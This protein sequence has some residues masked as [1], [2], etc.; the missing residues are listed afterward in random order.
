MAESVTVTETAIVTRRRGRR[1]RPSATTP[2]EEVTTYQVQL[3]V[4]RNAEAI[5]EAQRL[6]GW[7]IYVTHSAIEDVSLVNAMALYGEEWTVC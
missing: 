2:V 3:S 1:G 4:Q 6:A 5:A 7:G